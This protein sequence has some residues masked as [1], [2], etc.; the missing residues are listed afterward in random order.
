MLLPKSK[1][2]TIQTVSKFEYSPNWHCQFFLLFKLRIHT[3]SLVIIVY[4][5]CN[6]FFKL[7]NKQREILEPPA[8]GLKLA[9][10]SS[11]YSR[12]CIEQALFT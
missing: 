4:N 7:R 9:Y 10:M 12:N 5:L 3:L 11:Q 1:T 8:F 2:R 6:F